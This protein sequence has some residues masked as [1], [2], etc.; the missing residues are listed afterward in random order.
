[1]SGPL[2]ICTPYLAAG[3]I[4]GGAYVA[5]TPTV[6]AVSAAANGLLIERVRMWLPPCASLGGYG[7]GVI[8]LSVLDDVA[9]RTYIK[10]IATP[11]MAQDEVIEPFDVRLDL[12]L[13][14]GWSLEVSTSAEDLTVGQ[15]AMLSV[16][17]QGGEL[18]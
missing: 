8:L 16:L 13:P 6:V 17:A 7:A 9:A 11:I 10:A 5:G 15:I 18:G 14:S 2:F 3:V 4:G 12:V 1:M